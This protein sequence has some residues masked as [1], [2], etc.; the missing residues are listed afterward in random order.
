MKRI[1]AVI[2]LA[3]VIS[4]L[5]A[6]SA[7]ACVLSGVSVGA[8]NGHGNNP[9]RHLIT[10]LPVTPGTLHAGFVTP[11]PAVNPGCPD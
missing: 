9:S 6:T 10:C 11:S 3:L 2:G 7:L 5:W 1:I 4:A 8:P